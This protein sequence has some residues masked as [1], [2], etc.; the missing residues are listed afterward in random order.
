MISFIVTGF[1]PFGNVKENPTTTLTAKLVEYLREKE[2]HERKNGGGKVGARS[3]ASST[4]TLVIE[5]SAAA[6][7][8]QIDI[9]YDELV[10]EMESADGF[11]D[12]SDD[13]NVVILLHL[14]V[15]NSARHFRLET[16]AYNNA[17]FRIPDEQGYKPCRLPIVEGAVGTPMPTML[18]VPALVQ[19][20]NNSCSGVDLVTAIAS[21]D[22]G[23]F[24]C[25]YTYCYGLDKFQCSR[26]TEQPPQKP[27]VRCLFL[28]VPPFSV[29][30]EK[31]QL[32][33]VANLME[34]LEQQVRNIGCQSYAGA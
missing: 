16:C 19:Q 26:L 32:R 11:S 22:P 18:D 8:E 12:D 3:L 9:H 10:K 1:G 4:R 5:T 6:V 2:E 29:A 7:K 24:V 17:D 34:A 30:P 27:N 14:G 33:F 13:V 25:N 31:E 21:I 23:L 15:H 20:L 28:H